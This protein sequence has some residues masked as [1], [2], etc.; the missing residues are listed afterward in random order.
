MSDLEQKIR[1]KIEELEGARERFVQQANQQ[2]AH[3]NA[4]I[5][6]LKELIG[7]EVEQPQ[8]QPPEQA[9]QPTEEIDEN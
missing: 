6:D 5:R 9:E 8:G 4:E 3:F 2:V 7:E 1:C